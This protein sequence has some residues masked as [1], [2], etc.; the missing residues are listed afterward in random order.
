ME[1][2]TGGGCV[3]GVKEG[4][5][6]AQGS[7]GCGVDNTSTQTQLLLSRIQLHLASCV[8]V[9]RYR[10]DVGMFASMTELKDLPEAVC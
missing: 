3:E 7:E 4:A 6:G 10:Q 1:G 5:K 2:G 8:R 9:C